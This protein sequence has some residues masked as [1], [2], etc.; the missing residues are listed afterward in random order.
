MAKYYQLIDGRILTMYELGNITEKQALTKGYKTIN[1]PPDD[2]KQ[3]CAQSFKET[4]T[5]IE[6][7][8]VEIPI[9]KSE[10]KIDA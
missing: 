1:D 8:W 5:H 6:V 10:E 2:G 7:E 9:P 4:K 3:Y